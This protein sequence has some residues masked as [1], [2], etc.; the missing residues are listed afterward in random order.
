MKKKKKKTDLQATITMVLMIPFSLIV[1]LLITQEQYAIAAGLCM[2]F[3]LLYVV[4]YAEIFF[5]IWLL[6][7]PVLMSDA[8]AFITINAH[9]IVTFDRAVVIGLFGLLLMQVFF[10]TKRL[11]PGNILEMFL[12]GFL[13]LLTISIVFKSDDKFAA[14][15]IFLDSF[16][17]PVALYLLA[18]HYISEGNYFQLFTWALLIVAV[19]LSCTG[20]Y[21]YITSTDIL[22]SEEGI[23]EFSGYRR[24][25][26]PYAA[27]DALASILSMCFFIVV[28]H[29]NAQISKR[30]SN[31]PLV[32]LLGGILVLTATAIGFT[33]LRTIWLST[34]IAFVIWIMLGEKGY[35]KLLAAV[36][37]ILILMYT[38]YDHLKS[39]DIYRD[40]IKHEDSI[41]SR[42]QA[43]DHALSLYKKKPI[44]GI[45]FHNYFVRTKDTGISPWTHNSF[46]TALTD[47][48]VVGFALITI[49]TILIFSIAF[50]YYR[51]SSDYPDKQFSRAFIPIVLC[52]FVPWF[53][54]E[55]IYR[56]EI[57]K[58]F[59]AILGLAVGRSIWIERQT[60]KNDSSS[61]SI[62]EDAAS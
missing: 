58:F 45:G 16:F 5:F 2:M 19:Y 61:F 31:L 38:G 54:L 13:L 9:P 7:S 55:S 14:G 51:R 42:F 1:A 46:L 50:R 33:V 28:Y 27:S 3:L 60:F 47:T 20:I 57:N 39:T 40:R 10:R 34:M 29:L 24:V 41:E 6:F 56:P 17:I 53:S 26:G 36:P 52:F 15:R 23:Q 37:L 21:E 12:L 18:K 62:D 22:P 59:F 49:I 35:L 30:R 32:L 25:D 44:F 4:R 43:Y 11:L 8:F 48:G